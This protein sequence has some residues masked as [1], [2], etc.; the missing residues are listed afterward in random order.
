MSKNNSYKSDLIGLIGIMIFTIL[1]LFLAQKEMEK[2][3]NYQIVN[4]TIINKIYIPKK[5]VQ[6]EKYYYRSGWR[7]EEETYPAEYWFEFEYENERI[8]RQVDEQTYNIYR[9]GDIKPI[10]IHIKD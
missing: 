10:E 5:V 3:E 7:I 6:Y 1:L 4:A 8:K 2:F 9:I